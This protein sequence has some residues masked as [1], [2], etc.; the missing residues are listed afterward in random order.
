VL[1]SIGTFRYKL[2]NAQCK[3]RVKNKFEVQKK[4]NKLGEYGKILT[5]YIIKRFYLPFSL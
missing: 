4:S 5:D 3:E 2:K 1:L